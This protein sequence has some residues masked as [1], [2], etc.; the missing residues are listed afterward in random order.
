[1]AQY[2]TM[3]LVNSSHIFGNFQGFTETAPGHKVAVTKA[4]LPLAPLAASYKSYSLLFTYIYMRHVRGVTCGCL[5]L[6]L[7]SWGCCKWRS[8]LHYP[9]VAGSAAWTAPGAARRKTVSQIAWQTNM[10]ITKQL[11]VTDHRSRHS[12]GWGPS[13]ANMFTF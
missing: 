8:S 6:P 12:K 13:C 1:M 7:C 5:C 2:L 3:W 10:F 9:G 4:I 11:K